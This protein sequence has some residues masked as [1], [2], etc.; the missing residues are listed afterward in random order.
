VEVNIFKHKSPSKRWLMES[1][2]C[3]RADGK[4]SADIIYCMWDIASLLAR[5]CYWHH[6]GHRQNM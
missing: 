2:A 6:K 5:H 4:E 3:R 1:T